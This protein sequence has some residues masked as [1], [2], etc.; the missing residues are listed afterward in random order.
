M[1]NDIADIICIKIHEGLHFYVLQVLNILSSAFSQAITCME[2]GSFQDRQ[3]LTSF[4]EKMKVCI[5]LICHIDFN[6]LYASKSSFI[7]ESWGYFPIPSN[8]QNDEHS[9]MSRTAFNLCVGCNVSS[10][11]GWEKDEFSLNLLKK[12]RKE[13]YF[14][15]HIQGGHVVGWLSKNNENRLSKLWDIVEIL[16]PT[17]SSLDFP[18]TVAN[19]RKVEWCQKA[20]ANLESNFKNI[21]IA[22]FG[23]DSALDI[24]LTFAHSALMLAQLEED[25]MK[26]EALMKHALS[27]ILPPVSQN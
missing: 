13:T 10:F 14:G 20:L 21:P 22:S 27:I 25:E 2:G 17:L 24:L 23:E 3:N 9:I 4:L 6:N 5:S 15:I 7:T 11:S 19:A 12:N 16:V 18:A 26:T 1:H 8:W